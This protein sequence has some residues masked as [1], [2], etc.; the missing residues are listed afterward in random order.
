LQYSLEK[1]F[2]LNMSDYIV[3]FDCPKTPAQPI[4]VCPDS[5]ENEDSGRYF[6]RLA[7]SRCKYQ[8]R[9]F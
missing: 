6:H 5:D 2:L 4:Q 1:S 7:L 8:A 9:G 3:S